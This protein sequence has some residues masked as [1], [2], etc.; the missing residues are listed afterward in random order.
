ML[1]DLSSCLQIVK[2]AFTRVNQN[3]P[4]SMVE[5]MERLVERTKVQ[6]EDAHRIVVK[7]K[8]GLAAVLVI[9]EQWEQAVLMYR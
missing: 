4:L 3:K 6:A 9:R 1:I 2:G 7:A 5:V 8:N